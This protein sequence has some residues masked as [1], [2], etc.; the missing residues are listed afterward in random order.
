MK[1]ARLGF[2]LAST[3][4]GLGCKSKASGEGPVTATTPTAAQAADPVPTAPPPPTLLASLMGF[5]GEIDM[6]A[7]G[8]DPGKPAQPVN[9]LVKGDKLRVDVLPGTEAANMLGKGYLLVR[10]ADKKFDLVVESK[11]QVVEMDMTNPDLM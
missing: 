9:M 7:K 5:E 3:V 8:S 10:V 11:K 1:R 4:P 6:T 2:L